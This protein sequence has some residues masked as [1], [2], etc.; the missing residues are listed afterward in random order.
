MSLRI[1]GT[2]QPDMTVIFEPNVNLSSTCLH[3]NKVRVCNSSD[4]C[5]HDEWCPDCGALNQQ[6]YFC[7]PPSWT[8]PTQ[9]IYIKV[10]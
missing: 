2:I 6:S 8:L 3:E 7:D 4:N 9:S 10:T 5:N 1:N